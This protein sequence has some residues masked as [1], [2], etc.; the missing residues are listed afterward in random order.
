MQDRVVAFQKFATMYIEYVI[1]F[2]RLEDC[3]DQVRT[4]VR[5]TVVLSTDVPRG[6]RDPSC[7]FIV[8]EPL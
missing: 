4:Y 8:S 1:I 7:H 2:R 5:G 3:Y 6:T